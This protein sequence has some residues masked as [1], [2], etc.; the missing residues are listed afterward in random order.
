M[1]AENEGTLRYQR[2]ERRAMGK[3]LRDHDSLVIVVKSGRVQ[4]TLGR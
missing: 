1:T 2:S 4:A 3:A